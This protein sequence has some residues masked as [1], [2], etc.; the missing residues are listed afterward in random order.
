MN[1]LRLRNRQTFVLVIL[2]LLTVALWALFI[3][4]T[5]FAGTYEGPDFEFLLKPF[6]IGMT[7]IPLV[8]GGF[9]LL[10]ALHWGGIRSVVGRA[11]ASLS[12]GTIAW[13][14]GMVVWNYYLFFTDVEV[15][16]PSLADA[17]FICSW[18][19]WTY[20]IYELAKVGGAKF[21]L[22][23]QGS[24]IPLLLAPL[25][26]AALSYYLVITVARGGVIGL[27]GGAVKGFFDLFYPL[28]DIVIAS[29][30]LLAVILSRKLLG[31]IY[32]KA[33]LVLFAGFMMN[34]VSDIVFSYT[35]TMETYFNGHLVDLFFT[36]TM[37]TLALGL[38]MFR[39]DVSNQETGTNR[40]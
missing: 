20:G 32:R 8:G 7:V 31:G 39:P 16:Y 35:T 2:F 4:R 11:L 33:V 17:I 3:V 22:R 18:P 21:A 37:F 14:L 28:G 13:G 12:L 19:L 27:D 36:T 23:G 38:T 34:Y 1:I 10:N 25:L 29:A 6:L 26:M 30:T 5:G 40:K 15:P 24:K 9:G